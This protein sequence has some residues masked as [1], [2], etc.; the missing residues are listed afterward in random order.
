MEDSLIAKESLSRLK[1]RLNYLRT[2][3]GQNS[4]GAWNGIYSLPGGVSLPPFDAEHSEEIAKAF[5]Q[6][7]KE[8]VNAVFQHSPYACL[9]GITGTGKTTFVEKVLADENTKVYIGEENFAEWAK[10]RSPIEKVPPTRLVLFVD[11]ANF[12]SL[13]LS[14]YKGIFTG[15]ILDPESQ[16]LIQLS[17]NH[18]LLLACN[19]L[20]YGD[21]RVLSPLIEENGSAIVFEPMPQEYIYEK[22]LKPIFAKGPLEEHALEISLPILEVYSFL[23]QCSDNEVLVSSRELQMMALLVLSHCQADPDVEKA[24]HLFV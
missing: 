6:D 16:E 9:T 4:D 19:P 21:E 15:G 17:E 10:A 11:E 5:E 14:R 23:C 7:R 12:A 13:Q 1:A 24:L 2:N 20:S 8:K 18:Y 22:I 3:P